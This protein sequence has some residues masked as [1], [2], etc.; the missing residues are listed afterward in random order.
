MDYEG[1]LELVKQR[2]SIRRFR[3][4]PIPD[5]YV[6]KIIEAA[7]W[8]PSGANSQPWEFI[9]IKEQNLKN[10]IVELLKEDGNLSH[11][12]E[13]TRE[14]EMR[15]PA[16]S[17]PLQELPGFAEAPVFIVLCGDTR[18]KVAYPL[19]TLMRQSGSVFYSS[20]ASAFLYMHLAATTLGL[21]S[22]WVSTIAYPYVQCLTK[23]LLEIPKEFEIYDLMA[24]GYPAS[25]PKPRLVR[26]KEG[27]VHFNYYDK[28]KF[29]SEAE[30]KDLIVALR[31]V[32][33]EDYH[34]NCNR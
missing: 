7:R 27:I 9:V 21:G 10:R 24:V 25:G 22:Q 31:K 8:A 34:E 30:I 33:E 16:F 3:P 32:R 5:E 28:D 1:F 12:M 15:H 11:K 17:K 19:A 2:R 4:E 14:P 26:A 29:K 23:A 18:T 20:L 6:D 13:I